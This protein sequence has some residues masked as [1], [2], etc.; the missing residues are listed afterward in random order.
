MSIITRRAFHHNVYF[1]FPFISI[2][3]VMCISAVVTQFVAFCS[4]MADMV[5][6][7]K[8]HCPFKACVTLLRDSD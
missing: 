7:E 6:C 1:F 5:S 4:I 2:L 3:A 8:H